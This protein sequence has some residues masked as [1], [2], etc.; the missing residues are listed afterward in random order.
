MQGY[1]EIVKILKS[2]GGM[3]ETKLTPVSSLDYD[4]TVKELIETGSFPTYLKGEEVTDISGDLVIGSLAEFSFH[5]AAL[6][7]LFHPD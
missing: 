3:M 2:A 4:I 6:G 7:L 1:M 5:T